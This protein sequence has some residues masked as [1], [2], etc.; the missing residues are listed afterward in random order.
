MSQ[1]S[2]QLEADNCRLEISAIGQSPLPVGVALAATV[3][4]YQPAEKLQKK[5]GKTHGSSRARTRL[6]R[7]GATSC[8]NQGCRTSHG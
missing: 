7:A 8:S 5:L 2:H 4:P 3:T 1:G 6:L